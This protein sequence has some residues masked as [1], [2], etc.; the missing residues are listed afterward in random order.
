MP[1]A[2]ARNGDEPKQQAETVGGCSR[3]RSRC[4]E[5]AGQGAPVE[6]TKDVLIAAGVVGHHRTFI[7]S[8]DA[9]CVAPS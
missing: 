2:T 3:R 1:N 8:C 6:L 4:L 5:A 7:V 9:T